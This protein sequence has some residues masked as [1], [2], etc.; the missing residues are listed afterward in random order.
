MYCLLNHKSIKTF[1]SALP[2]VC[3]GTNCYSL[4]GCFLYVTC[5]NRRD[6]EKILFILFVFKPIAPGLLIHVIENSRV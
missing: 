6:V 3:I 1:E 5:I 2:C 4:I